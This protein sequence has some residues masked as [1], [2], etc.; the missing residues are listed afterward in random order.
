MEKLE[1][2]VAD[3]AAYVS[4][5]ETTRKGS[6]HTHRFSQAVQQAL[7]ERGSFQELS[8]GSAV[9]AILSSGLGDDHERDEVSFLEASGATA[10]LTLI[11]INYL[12]CWE[13]SLTQP[14]TEVTKRLAAEYLLPLVDYFPW[15]IKHKDDYA[16]ASRLTAR[17]MNLAKP[18]I[19]LSFG[20]LVRLKFPT[21]Y[22]PTFC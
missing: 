4:E 3:V 14:D 6:K 17:Y 21:S 7:V 8:D 22:C 19:V 20:K 9:I 5:H 2:Y 11:L 1:N 13:S 12:R 15:Y 18:Y 10:D 16:A